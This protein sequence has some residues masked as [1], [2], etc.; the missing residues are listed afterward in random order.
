LSV[1]WRN[2]KKHFEIF[3]LSKQQKATHYVR[4]S[5]S[6]NGLWQQSNHQLERSGKRSSLTYQK[7]REFFSSVT[8]ILECISSYEAWL[9]RHTSECSFITQSD[10][11]LQ[12]LWQ[13]F[14]IVV[15]LGKSNS[16]WS[17]PSIFSQRTELCGRKMQRKN[18]KNTLQN[19]SKNESV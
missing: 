4:H 2:L 15:S 3:V 19:G 13:I 11:Q 14:Y 12:K 9:S 17:S 5:P 18:K 7:W 16:G 1:R 10:C 6:L 8:Y